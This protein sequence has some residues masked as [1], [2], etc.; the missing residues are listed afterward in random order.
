MSE[1]TPD[2]VDLDLDEEKLEK[3]DEVKSD[4]EINPDGK[5]M[6]NVWDAGEGGEGGDD[7]EDEPESDAQ[8]REQVNDVD[9]P[10]VLATDADEKTRHEA[11]REDEEKG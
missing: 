11:T 10:E 9:A 1:P 8:H 3:W 6:P 7:P 2:K 5:P 4:Y